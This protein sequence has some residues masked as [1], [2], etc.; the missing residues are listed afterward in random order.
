M[1]QTVRALS[2]GASPKTETRAF[3]EVEILYGQSLQADPEYQLLQTLPF[4]CSCLRIGVLCQDL[5]SVS[6]IL[7]DFGTKTH[8]IIAMPSWGFIRLFLLLTVLEAVVHGG[9]A[10]FRSPVQETTV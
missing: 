4:A 10:C 8:L 7:H 9:N 5:Q 2:H 6:L 1:L 3:L